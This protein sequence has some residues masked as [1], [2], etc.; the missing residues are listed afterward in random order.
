MGETRERSTLLG[1]VFPCCEMVF[2]LVFPTSCIV[3]RLENL[4]NGLHFGISS[5]ARRNATL[6]EDPQGIHHGR[7]EYVLE[8]VRNLYGQKQAGRVWNKH[9]AK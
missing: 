9:L 8:L 3:A 2:Y 4:A 6:H 1:N 5:G 7:Q